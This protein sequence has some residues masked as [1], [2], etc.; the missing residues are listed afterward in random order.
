MKVKILHAKKDQR[1]RVTW[2][3]KKPKK[4]IKKIKKSYKLL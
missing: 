3:W 2:N 1:I 4:T